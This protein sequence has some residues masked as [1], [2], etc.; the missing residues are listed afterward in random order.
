MH[1]SDNIPSFIF[2]FSYIGSFQNLNWQTSR[3]SWGVR[4]RLDPQ[5]GSVPFE[6]KLIGN[7]EKKGDMKIIDR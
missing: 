6:K 3:Q 7:L 1:R 5:N 4:E 2:V